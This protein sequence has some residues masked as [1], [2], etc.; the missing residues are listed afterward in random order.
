MVRF[1][2]YPVIYT[3]VTLLCN[4]YNYHKWPTCITEETDWHSLNSNIYAYKLEESNKTLK[5]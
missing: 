1:L 5:Q 2:A 3:S 4:K